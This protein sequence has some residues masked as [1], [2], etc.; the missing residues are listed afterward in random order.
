MTEINPVPC[1]WRSG[2]Y[3]ATYNSGTAD[4]PIADENGREVGRKAQEE[5]HQQPHEDAGVDGVDG[6]TAP[7]PETE[8]EADRLPAVEDGERNEQHGRHD[9]GHEGPSAGASAHG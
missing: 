3:V 1:V 4:W 2:N 6:L 8:I 9:S 5:H 7:R